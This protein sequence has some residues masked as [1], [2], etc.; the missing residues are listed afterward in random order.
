MLVGD[1][2]TEGTSGG[3]FAPPEVRDAVSDTS[4]WGDRCSRR[5]RG[6]HRAEEM[7]TADSTRLSRNATSEQ[8][9]SSRLTPHGRRL[10]TIFPR[11]IQAAVAR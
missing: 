1:T 3:T 6:R 8:L 9:R 5:A 4:R 11:L 7:A 10:P 2:L